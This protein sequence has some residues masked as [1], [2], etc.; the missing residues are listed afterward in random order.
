MLSGSAATGW[1]RSPSS[2]PFEGV[3][4]FDQA[5]WA[6]TSR[7]FSGGHAM[8]NKVFG[9][10]LLAAG[11]LAAVSVAFAAPSWAGG[12]AEP[13]AELARLLYTSDRYEKSLDAGAQLLLRS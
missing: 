8:S 7:L 5:L 1:V 3:T 4:R 2:S 13:G 11:V 6:L 10:G 9:C 12:V